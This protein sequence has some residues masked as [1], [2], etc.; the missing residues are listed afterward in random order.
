MCSNENEHFRDETSDV[1][2]VI[3]CVSV[4]RMY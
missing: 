2:Y 1:T 3:E 4:I